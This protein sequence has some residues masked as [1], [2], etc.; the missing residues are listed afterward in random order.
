MQLNNRRILNQRG[1]SMMDVMLAMAVAAAVSTL[2]L[3]QVL[4]TKNNISA[5]NYGEEM[6]SI[7]AAAANYA[8]A[9]KTALLAATV[10]GTGASSVCMV[11]VASNGTGGSAAYSTTTHTCAVDV[12]WLKY[13]GWLPPSFNPLT[14]EGSSWAVI[15]KQDY[16]GTTATGNL[17]ALIVAASQVGSVTF[18]PTPNLAT[19]GTVLEDAAQLMGGN[20]GV[21]PKDS[22]QP[23]PW[24]ATDNTQQYICGADGGWRVSV[25]DFVN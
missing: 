11:N 21:V 14:P 18:S 24:N 2:M 12:S 10:D 8:A 9:N 1:M 3:K 25:G 19:K 6:Q 13:Q 5:K 23:C 17:E 4:S 20:A 7:Y 15:Y 16:N 22:N